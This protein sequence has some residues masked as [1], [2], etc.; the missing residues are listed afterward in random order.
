[1]DQMYEDKL[2]GKIDQEFW[3]CKMNE[4]RE[5]ERALERSFRLSATP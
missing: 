1:M 2:D 5:Q 3:A 4:W